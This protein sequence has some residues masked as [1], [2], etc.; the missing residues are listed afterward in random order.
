MEDT[1]RWL[2]QTELYLKT[3][4][5]VTLSDV[6]KYYE[7]LK[8]LSTEVEERRPHLELLTQR[9]K[10]LSRMSSYANADHINNQVS[11][12]GT[13]WTNVCTCLSTKMH[14]TIDSLHY[15]RRFMDNFESLSAWLH[16]L[17]GILRRDWKHFYSCSPEEQRSKIKAYRKE[18]ES[19]EAQRTSVNDSTLQLIDKELGNELLRHIMQQRD[20]LN[21][22]WEALC[23]QLGI[24][25]KKA[26]QTKYSL[27]LLEAQ[28]TQLNKWMSSVER[29]IT[30]ISGEVS[31]DIDELN[32]QLVDLQISQRE[33]NARSPDVIS[34]LSLCVRLQ[35]CAFP[36]DGDAGDLQIARDSFESRWKKISRNVGQLLK[37][38][39][40]RIALCKEFRDDYKQFITWLRTFENLVTIPS[41]SCEDLHELSL[42]ISRLQDLKR[43]VGAKGV[44]VE[45]LL[46][47]GNCLVNNSSSSS[48]QLIRQMIGKTQE[49]WYDI[50]QTLDDSIAKFH[51]LSKDFVEF[52]EERRN[53]NAWL[54]DIEVR[55]IGLEQVGNEGQNEEQRL[56]EL[57]T[58]QHHI[59]MKYGSL[60]ELTSQVTKLKGCCSI[61]DYRLQQQ[62]VE[63]LK[64]RYEQALHYSLTLMLDLAV[65][66]P[67]SPERVSTRLPVVTP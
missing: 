52:E 50:T 55:L 62:K 37:Q 56:Q 35:S 33:I 3:C 28:L 65:P 1:M 59:N 14:R 19:H 32:Q 47:R 23:I 34:V 6:E 4:S 57:K 53:V 41:G 45:R 10:R 5:A 16:R 40:D 22:R 44:L 24:S 38:N 7:R 51:L 27:K 30:E 43:Q 26:E 9:G 11:V 21:E 60:S 42:E 8:E 54:T 12:M 67:F 15:L 39:Q 20:T 31:C 49:R 63:E 13:L 48:A 66:S 64:L 17:E 58:L 29:Q 25:Y 18:I 2:R 36:D 61:S 46:T